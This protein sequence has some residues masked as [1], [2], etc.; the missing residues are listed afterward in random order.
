MKPTLD[1]IIATQDEQLDYLLT[2]AERQGITLKMRFGEQIDPVLDKAAYIQALAKRIDSTQAA[3]IVQVNGGLRNYYMHHFRETSRPALDAFS[4][5][6]PSLYPPAKAPTLTQSQALTTTLQGG[7]YV[8]QCQSEGVPVPDTVQVT[9]GAPIFSG[10]A[11]KPPVNQWINWGEFGNEFTAGGLDAELW[12]YHS[13]SPAG[14]C[15]ALPRWR[16]QMVSAFGIVCLGYD[17]SKVCYFDEGNVPSGQV[18]TIQSFKSGYALYEEYPGAPLNPGG[19]CTDCH[20]GGN[21]FIIHPDYAPFKLLRKSATL[22]HSNSWPEPIVA[23][24]WP[25]NPGPLNSLGP[26]PQG[27]STCM[28]CHG[29]MSKDKFPQLSTA[30]PRYC[31]EI[32]QMTTDSFFDTMPPGVETP[33]KY[34]T[35]IDRIR[36]LCNQPPNNGTIVPDVPQ[37]DP[38]VVSPP[39]VTQPLYACATTVEVTGALF[40]AELKLIVNNIQVDSRIVTNPYSEEF[41]VSTPFVKYDEVSAIQTLNGVSS[42]PSKKVEVRNHAEDYKNGL[43]IPII[44]PV[45]LYE[46]ARGVAVRHVPGATLHL[47]VN[48]SVDSRWRGSA[49]GYSILRA[50]TPFTLGNDVTIKQG[51]CNDWSDL[52]QKATVVQGPSQLSAPKFSKKLAP[53]Q[54]MAEINLIVHGANVSVREA[55][56]GTIGVIES[57]PFTTKEFNFVKSTLSRPYLATD[58]VTLS[59]E[60]CPGTES[61]PSSP[62]SVLPCEEIPAPKIATPFDGD[63]FVVVTD[64]ILGATIRVWSDNQSAEI[65]DGAGTNIGLTRPLV[66]NERLIVSQQIG[67]C[68]SQSAYSIFVQ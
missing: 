21:P 38:R 7:A 1:L 16:G 66:F 68:I 58:S 54:Y 15:L 19:I 9:R 35:H 46:C 53:G 63:T 39:I 57:W 36:D 51:L 20:A 2:E 29:G 44:D 42:D 50:N 22:L 10:G 52:S 6:E 13:D 23:P 32:I 27:E 45:L 40:G 43:P 34:R 5:P 31:A 56:A 67:E 64:S 62:A 55:S 30:L 48:M 65:G 59:Q 28:L 33:A 49:G 14:V 47:M 12:S 24:Q 4:P 41:I 25:Q 8:S 17:S 61:P 3:W 37:D 26:V 60:L 18:R 11:G